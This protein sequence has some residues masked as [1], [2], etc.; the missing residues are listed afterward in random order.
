MDER[1]EQKPGHPDAE[2]Y[3]LDDYTSDGEPEKRQ[4]SHAPDE[5]S[6]EDDDDLPRE[7]ELPKVLGLCTFR[8]MI[9]ELR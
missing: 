5:S 9:N 3:L 8:S 7:L 2:L 1:K 6:D 4:C